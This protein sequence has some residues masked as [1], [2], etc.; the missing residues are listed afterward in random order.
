M[1]FAV[2]PTVVKRSAMLW[3]V[4]WLAF[5]TVNLAVAKPHAR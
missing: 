2:S 4:L 3:N 1:T 5:Q